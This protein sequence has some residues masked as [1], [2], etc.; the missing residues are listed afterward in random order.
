MLFSRGFSQPRDWMQVSRLQV[1]S[2]LAEPPEKPSGFP[3]FFQ[4][5]SE[6]CNKESWSEPQSAPGLVFFWL[7]I[8]SPSLAAKNIINLISLLTIWWCP[9]VDSSLGC[10]L[11]LVHFLG[12]TLLVFGLL[13]SVFQGQICLLLQVFLDFLVLYSSPLYEKDIFF[14][15][16]RRSCRSS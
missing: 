12:K 11:W 6:F 15:C 14:G 13:H 3:Y 9:C 16:S 7:Y 1:D 10:L 2:L 5:K 8:A 4:F